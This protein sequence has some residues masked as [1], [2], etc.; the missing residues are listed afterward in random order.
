MKISDLARSAAADAV[1]DL[2]DAGR[3]DTLTVRTG[4]STGVTVLHY[5]K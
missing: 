1:V 3:A 4:S 2:L 5:T